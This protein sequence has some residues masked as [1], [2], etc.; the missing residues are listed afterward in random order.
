MRMPNKYK[1]W[2]TKRAW[3]N[4]LRVS[5]ALFFIV[6]LSHFAHTIV[7]S[8]VTPLWLKSLYLVGMVFFFSFIL[9]LLAL[10]APEVMETV[11]RMLGFKEKVKEE[12][13]SNGQDS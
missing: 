13:K 9:W 10:I 5:V 4:C 6:W 12:S 2:L 3:F 7:F 1:K 8:K 11:F